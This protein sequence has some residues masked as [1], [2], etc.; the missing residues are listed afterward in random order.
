MLTFKIFI[1][2]KQIKT[3]KVLKQ[4]EGFITTKIKCSRITKY[5]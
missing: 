1:M 3:F 2:E 5:P 4:N